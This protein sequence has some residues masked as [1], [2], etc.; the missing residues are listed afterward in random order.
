[1]LGEGRIARLSGI[2][3]SLLMIMLSGGRSP[4][5]RGPA[6]PSSGGRDV[7]DQDPRGCADGLAGH[8]VTLGT[9]DQ[10]RGRC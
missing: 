6:S 2:Q 7:P 3:V 4:S 9:N 8:H 10:G 5:L 1:M